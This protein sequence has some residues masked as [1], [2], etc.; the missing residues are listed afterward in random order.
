MFSYQS[1]ISGCPGDF[2]RV[3]LADYTRILSLYYSDVHA[4]LLVVIE[5]IKDS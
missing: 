2:T 5:T 1:G 3:D 4:G